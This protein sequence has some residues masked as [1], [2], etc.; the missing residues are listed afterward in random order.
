MQIPCFPQTHVILPS[1]K[2]YY[3]RA[4]V[5]TIG[6]ANG[7]SPIRGQVFT[8]TNL[9]LLLIGCLW[10]YFCEILIK[11]LTSLWRKCIDN[12]VGNMSA[13]LSRFFNNIWYIYILVKLYHGNLNTQVTPWFNSTVFRVYYVTNRWIVLSGYLERTD[14]LWELHISKFDE[15]MHLCEKDKIFYGGHYQCS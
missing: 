9:D 10:I 6:S 1:L 3:V 11:I 2:V 7:L 5:V 8:W 15:N 4:N 14:V 13:I 12:V